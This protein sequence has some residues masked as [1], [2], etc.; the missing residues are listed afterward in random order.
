MTV[1]VNDDHIEEVRA[2]LER[3]EHEQAAALLGELY[4]SDIARILSGIE[5]EEQAVGAFRSLPSEV[6]GDVLLE[7][8]ERLREILVSAISPAELIEVVDE[9]DS[10]DVTD[11]ISELPPEDVKEVL[12][13]LD[14]EE[15]IKV[16]KLLAYPE[17]VAG[18]KMQAELIAVDKEATVQRAIE[19]VRAGAKAQD[20]EGISNIFVVDSEERLVG[21]L[22]LDRLIL[23]AP[24]ARIGDIADMEPHKVETDLDQEEVAR[25]FR[26]HDLLSLPVVDH[27]NRLVGRITVDDVVDVI[28][29][30]IFEDFYRMAGVHKD[31]RVLDPPRSSF[32]MRFPWLLLNLFTAFLAA[33]VV[34]VFQDAIEQLVLLAVLMPIVAGLGGNAGTQTITVMVRGLA[35]GEFKFV[36]AR[37]VILKE[38]AV[39]FLNG[40]IIGAAAAFIA[41]LFGAAPALGLLLFMAMIVNLVIAGF[42]GAA[43]PLLLRRFKVDPAIASSTFVT[44]CTDIGGFFVFLGLATV[45]LRM[46]FL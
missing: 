13:G 27:D 33:S 46:G 25:I 5:E 42:A 2:L 24:D 22:P 43:I 9:M 1:D 44:T 35:L 6:A 34:R 3:G 37:R 45:F 19:E 18:G 20:I 28:E 39:G 4:A 40:L 38:V 17:D 11:V 23:A 32:R 36:N 8:D 16:A 30:E 41:Y 29:E 14:K 15:A 12:D 21:V 7:V 26:R 10:D 31:E